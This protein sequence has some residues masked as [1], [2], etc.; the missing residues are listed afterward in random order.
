M[1]AAQWEAA[2]S[3]TGS[4]QPTQPDQPDGKR[5][6]ITLFEAAE[7]YAAHC[8]N[9]GIQAATLSKY[10]TFIKQL[11]AYGESRG[12]VLVE[13]LMVS[14]MDGFY[15]SWKDGKRARAKKLERLKS[16]VRFCLK[17]EWLNKDITED[18]QA[19]E[20]SSIPENKAPFTDEE[21]ACIYAACDAL[22][23]PISPG[24]GYRN[25]SG[26]G[27]KDFIMMSVYT[28]CVFRILRPLTP[29]SGCTVMTC[30]CACIRHGKSFIR[31][32][33][34]GWRRVCMNAERS[35]AL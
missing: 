8:E 10:R 29:M 1:I 11:L 27:V 14:D 28:G 20:G 22:G 19:P 5:P 6:I 23:E 7:A 30:S 32:F 33:P 26:E 17:R 9:R 12:Y 31:G 18:L 34:I 21:M 25:W 15:A 35:T 13:Q 3:W 24:P 2:G 4:I 16:F